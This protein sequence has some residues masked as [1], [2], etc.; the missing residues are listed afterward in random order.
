V[1]VVGETLCARRSATVRLIFKPDPVDAGRTPLG[2]RP[3][4]LLEA[5]PKPAPRETPSPSTTGSTPARPEDQGGDHSKRSWSLRGY[6]PAAE[7]AENE[8]G[9]KV[10]QANARRGFRR[11]G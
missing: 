3:R 9:K 7:L 11:G 10:P 8:P 1:R 6:S 2:S 4:Q 5:L